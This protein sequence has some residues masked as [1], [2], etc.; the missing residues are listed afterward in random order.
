MS[1]SKFPRSK[2]HT[3]YFHWG[4][5]DTFCFGPATSTICLLFNHLLLP[6]SF[7]LTV[8]SSDLQVPPRS[9]FVLRNIYNCFEDMWTKNIINFGPSFGFLIL[10]CQTCPETE[11]DGP[12]PHLS[13]FVLIR[14]SSIVDIFHF[15]GKNFSPAGCERM[16]GRG[17]DLLRI[18]T[19]TSIHEIHTHSRRR[20]NCTLCL[21]YITQILTGAREP[22]ACP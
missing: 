16:N 12:S 13:T 8:S 5:S 7:Q 10:S 4:T 21:F 3:I 9:Q 20:R 11:I 1:I 2:N 15:S 17:W 6:Q 22:P 14:K 19:L 18:E